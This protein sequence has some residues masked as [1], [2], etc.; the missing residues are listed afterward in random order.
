MAN[1]SDYALGDRHTSARGFILRG[2]WGWA[3]AGL[4]LV[5]SAV[6]LDAITE[7]P[8]D[9]AA[10]SFAVVSPEDWRG[11]SARLPEVR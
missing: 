6:A 3:S 8:A 1:A 7:P 10:A 11:N 2:A 5:G 9:T 4:L